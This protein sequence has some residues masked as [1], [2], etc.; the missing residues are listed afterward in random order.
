MSDHS[1]SSSQNQLIAALQEQTQAINA[2]AQSNRELVA[3]IS[4]LL[5][6]GAEQD[7]DTEPTHYMDGSPML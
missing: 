5:A 3:V 1:E 7:P 4:D 6:E 2:L